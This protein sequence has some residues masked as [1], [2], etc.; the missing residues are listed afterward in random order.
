MRR[1]LPIV[2]FGCAL[3]AASCVTY[4]EELNRGQRHFQASEYE[5]ALAIWRILEHDVDS[6][7]APDRTR[8]AYLRG[9]TDY[10]MSLRTDARYW[11]GLAR[12]YEQ[13]SPGGIEESWRDRMKE[14]LKDLDDD[15]YGGAK[16]AQA[17]DAG[18]D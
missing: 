5:R 1:L 7:P 4:A 12:A 14:A 15:V 2:L 11:L 18:A 13:A 9:M 17:T 16:T 8:Y 6:L 10:R 3:S